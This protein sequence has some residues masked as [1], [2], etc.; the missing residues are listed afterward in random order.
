MDHSEA[1]AA[2]MVERYVLGE[3]SGAERDAFEEHYFSCEVCG[4][5]LRAALQI[6]EAVRREGSAGRRLSR[7]QPPALV[8]KSAR[9]GVASG[10]HRQWGAWAA[11]L[12]V[13]VGAGYQH[14]VQVPGLRS[15]V[16]EFEQPQLFTGATVLRMGSRA[17]QPGA[18]VQHAGQPLHF[19]LEIPIESQY[20]E[21]RV[22]I[23]P[24]EGAPVLKR[25]PADQAR[26]N[27][28]LVIPK[29]VAGTY[30]V[31]VLGDSG[32]GE[33][34]LLEKTEIQVQ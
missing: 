28:V 3:L 23:S 33:P 5:E 24:P 21:Y 30:Q 31:A 13:T 18:S 32:Q 8:Q 16:R 4:S 12:V 20:K 11:V 17:V 26:D 25:V 14:F 34:R 15:A 29:A 1:A 22:L 7:E 2:G 10:I 27:V 9:V 6:E 19:F